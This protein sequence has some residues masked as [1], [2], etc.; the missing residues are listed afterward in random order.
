MLPFATFCAHHG[1]TETQPDAKR[2][3][4]VYR[5]QLDL[6]T[7]SAPV[8]SEISGKVNSRM[9][10]RL[11]EAQHPLLSRCVIMPA[12]F[13]ALKGWVMRLED[14]LASRHETL[15]TSAG[16]IRTFKS[17]DSAYRVAKRIGFTTVNVTSDDMPIVGTWATNVI[18]RELTETK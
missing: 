4:E 2:Q 17:L 1:L 10:R 9:A 8:D 11:F 15:R 16:V 13:L 14:E 3:Y 12:R 6:F 7:G 5:R 18:D